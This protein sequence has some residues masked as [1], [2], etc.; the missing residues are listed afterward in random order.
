MLFVF[1]RNEEIVAKLENGNKDSC[2]YYDA[3]VK[4]ILNGEQIL[5][6]KTSLEHQDAKLIEEY[7][8]IARKNKFNKWQLFLITELVETHADTLEIEVTAE[9]SLVELDGVFIELMTFDRKT[10]AVV[11]PAILAGTRWEVGTI[12]GTEI[13][14]LTIKNKSVLWALQKF[15]ERWGLELSFEIEITANYI[16]K[17]KVNCY[18]TKGLWNGKRFEYSKDLIEVVRNIE[19]KTI[20]TALYGVG[21]EIE[22]SNG[23]R[24]DFANVV[25]VTGVNGAPMNKPLGQK[26]LGDDDAKAIWGKKTKAGD[27]T[28][29]HIFGMYETTENTD[30]EDLLWETW[31]ALQSVKTPNVTYDLKV[32]DLFKI[33]GLEPEAMELGDQGAIIDKDLGLELQ[34]RIIEYEEDLVNSE[35]DQLVLGNFVPRFTD[36]TN[37]LE[38]LE[39][40]AYRQGE[41]I[42]PSW[43]DTQFDFAADA[44]RLG[45]GTVIM[46]EGEGILIVDDPAN[47]QKAIKL[48]A[49]QLSL[50]DSRNIQTNTF[51]WRNFGTGGGWLSDLVQAGKIRFERAEGGLL[52]L[53]GPNN[54][55]GQLIVYDSEGRIIGDLDADKGGFTSLYVGDFTADNVLNSN[56]KIIVY[57]VY[58][59]VGNDNNDGLSNATAFKTIQRAINKIPKHNNGRVEIYVKDVVFNESEV[60]IE[61][62]FGS[63][64]IA[65]YFNTAQHNGMIYIIQ[66][67][68][69]V[70]LYDGFINQSFGTQYLR[71]GTI[72][73]LR[74]LDVIMKNMQVYSVQNVDFGVK[75]RASHLTVDSC[76]FYDSTTAG[77]NAEFGGIVELI[78][79]NYGSGAWSGLRAIGTGRIAVLNNTAPLGT[80]NI[81]VDNGG[82]VIGTITAHSAGTP[83]VLS[84]PPLTKRFALAGARS[85]NT[86]T[87]WNM[88]N[89]FIYQGE[90]QTKKTDA[91]GNFYTTYSGNWKGCFWFNNDDIVTT[92]VNRTV[93]SARIKLRRLSYGGFSGAYL[94]DLWTT[95]TPITE[96]G[97]Q[98]QPVAD[99]KIGG[100][101]TFSWGENDTIDIPPWVIDAIKS[102]SYKGFML[103]V[104]NGANYMIL[105]QFAELELTY[106]TT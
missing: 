51:N 62:F 84:A 33:I 38:I 7:G 69:R 106:E 42:P 2:P 11:L 104:A 58:P 44:I 31:V 89:N 86:N 77:I 16:S 26:W 81:E 49:G 4:S 24:M 92:L 37:K 78:N 55:S 80:V 85:W 54:G 70:E 102:G 36:L 30:S 28:K 94:A 103:Y 79:D 25:W 91:N 73:I 10:P 29:Q 66:N 90:L 18:I 59:D 95:P 64:S 100:G 9:H 71:D 52:T 14:D 35:N 19:A 12:A 98:T 5:N 56:N 17:R 8:Y 88:N 87:G 47:P 83:S 68:Q 60:R 99:Y 27:N 13:H 41:P 61:G 39:Q 40:E 20:K 93:L 82:E 74:T 15:C 76:N 53:G 101:T 57:I 97:T 63:G 22:D 48:N 1:N 6:F 65:I 32:I 75:V 45:G 96:A 46:N 105:D 34:A 3:K 50:A 23:L 43:L 67:V 72:T 21:K